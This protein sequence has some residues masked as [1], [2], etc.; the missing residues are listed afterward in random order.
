FAIDADARWHQPSDFRP[1]T[2]ILVPFAPETPMSGVGDTGFYDA[3][4]YRRTFRAPRLEPGQRLLLHFGAV[5][6]AARVWVNDRL[7]VEHEGG[8]TPFRA[9]IIDLLTDEAQQTLCV[10]A[11]DDP[12]DL[13]KPRGKQD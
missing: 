10:R 11:F 8:Y 13:A 2:R 6:H 3:V 9:D 1:Q 5:D 12:Q 4:W 7:A